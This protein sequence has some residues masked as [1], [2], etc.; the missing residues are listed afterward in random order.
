LG[1]SRLQIGRQS[2]GHRDKSYEGKTHA[3]L[4]NVAR[5]SPMMLPNDHERNVAPEC[6]P[7]KV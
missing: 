2:G 1:A 5:W 6:I 7:K 4:P 3:I